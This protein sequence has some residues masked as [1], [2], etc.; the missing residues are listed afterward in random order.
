MAKVYES[1]R[2]NET[3]YKQVG[4]ML[5]GGDTIAIVGNSGGNEDPVYTSN[6]ATRANRSTPWNGWQINNTEGIMRLLEKTGLVG[7]GLVAGVSLSLHFAA[8]A[9]K[10][11]LTTSLPV[12]ELRAFS[13]VFGRI[14]SDYVEPVTD[15]KL[16]TEAINGMLN[17]LDPTPPISTW[18][19][20]RSCKSYAG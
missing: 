12:E 16:I 4:D 15:K 1:V 13:E 17:G 19:H 14:K 9:E 8:V 5:N 3:L 7:L 6:C 10:E 2:N 11:T 20:S 18:N